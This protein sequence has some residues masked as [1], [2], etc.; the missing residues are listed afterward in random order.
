MEIDTKG[1]ERR[2]FA[3]ATIV[4][5]KRGLRQQKIKDVRIK[6]SKIKHEKESKFFLGKKVF[7]IPKNLNIKKRKVIW[8]KIKKLHGRSG[9][10]IAQ[11][12]KNLPPNSISMNVNISYL[13][14]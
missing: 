2:N 4:G 10:F 5:F 1:R 12:K 11:F 14:W 7:F 13:P 8:G 3:K 6:I 9:V